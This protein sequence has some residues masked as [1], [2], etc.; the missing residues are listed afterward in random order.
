MNP[1]TK[2][3][4]VPRLTRRLLFALAFVLPALAQAQV[5]LRQITVGDLPVTLVYPTASTARVSTFGPF[6]LQVARDAEPT[7]GQHHLIVMSHGT[8]GNALSDHALAATLARAG[9]VVA[10][11]LHQ[12]D[13]FQDHSLAGPASWDLR[14]REVSRVIDALLK[15][16]SW[17]DRLV[18]DRVGVHGMSAGGVTALSLAGAQWRLL[19]MVR[20]CQAHA[21]D[22]AGFCFSG[23]VDPAAVA[24]RRAR[25]ESARDV[26]ESYLPADLTAV[27]G[28]RTAKAPAEDGRPDPRVAAVTVAVPL[29]AIFTAESLA[30]VRVPVGVVSAG[31]DEWLVPA[32]H[33]SRLLE[34]CRACTR[35][36]DLPGAA[37]MDL[38]AP[39]P[40][41][42]ATAVA[43]TQLRGA[44]PA[45]GFDARERDVAFTAIGEFFRRELSR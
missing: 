26:P 10:Q 18:A 41:T 2:P 16:P 25:Y 21:D 24:A 30:H 12:G 31:R 45:P 15:D 20:H 6:E 28:G 36:I 8:G 33:S 34:L 1:S 37:H 14:P 44:Q 38:L 9:F 39:W 5:G 7:P 13:N 43:K 35:L 42:V 17:K 32:F 23:L 29:A 40:A 3:N 27:H 19:D 4:R 22:D 11:P